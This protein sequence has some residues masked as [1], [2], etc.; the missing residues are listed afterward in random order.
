M[1]APAR[2]AGPSRAA[3]TAAAAR[4]APQGESCSGCHA[5]LI[6]KRV[7]HG[8]ITLGDCRNCHRPEPGAAGKCKGK[9]AQHWTLIRTEP[10]LCYGCHDRKDQSKS[11]H[12]A[13]RQGSCLSCHTAHSSNEPKLLSS[14]REK[15]CLD[16]HE[17]EPLLTKAVKH[18]PVAEGRCLDCHDAHGGDLPNAI[19]ASSGSAF[20]LKCHDAKAPTGKGTPGLAYRIDLSKPNVHVALK[21]GDC[22]TCHEGGHSGDNLKLLRKNAVDLCYGCHDR[23]DKTKYPH[24]AVIVGDCAV[25]H[26]PHSSAQP[27]LLAKPTIQETCFL[28][29]Q[30][31]VTGRKVVHAPLEKGCNQCHDA[32]G[33]DNRKALK[34]EG[35]K[36][37]YGCHKPVDE[38][39]VKHAALERYGCTGCH[40]PHGTNNGGLVPKKVNELCG[41]CH[42][43]QKDGRHVSPL[44]PTGHVVG[45]KLNDP[46]REGRTFSCASCHN[47]HGSNS[48]KLFYV[49]KDSMEM[50]AA[51]HGDKSGEHPELK[52]VVSKARR[53]VGGPSGEAGF[54][55]GGAGG[56]GAA[57]AGGP[58]VRTGSGAGSGG[59]DTTSTFQG[60]RQ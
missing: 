29:H 51:C 40:D 39:K 58:G 42:P 25:C 59:G 9:T 10:D 52:N 43:D 14:P 47:P 37:C 22:T 13:V 19:K 35:K 33:T 11:V 15:I 3:A 34:A 49:G 17:V 55:A 54:G 41:F 44:V 21:R 23:K 26:D 4:A 8:A 30:D 16:C 12:T 7:V 31:D 60:A 2:P 32:H 46:R 27:K 56:P 50:C 36:V 1:T 45:G 18:A 57:G 24:S 38:G 5:Q 48:P 28:C 53:N 20:C 6:N